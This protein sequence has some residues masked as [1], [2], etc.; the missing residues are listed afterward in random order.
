VHLEG[1]LWHQLDTMPATAEVPKRLLSNGAVAGIL[2]AFAAGSYWWSMSAVGQND[3]EKEVQR[4]VERQ[5]R[6][7]AEQR[8]A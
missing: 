2:A 4:E 6:A 5:Q 7:A 3:I 1:G 8:G